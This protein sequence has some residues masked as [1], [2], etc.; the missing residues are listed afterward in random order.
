MRTIKFLFLAVLL[1]VIASSCNN[2]SITNIEQDIKKTI[3]EKVN[4]ENIYANINDVKLINESGNK[5]TGTVYATYEGESIEMN[6]S[7]IY[8]GESYKW[9]IDPSEINRIMLKKD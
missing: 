6:I 9:E 7:L 3:Q 2:K 1:C 8:D 5:Y 4:K